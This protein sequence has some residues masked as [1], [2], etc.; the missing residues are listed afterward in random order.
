MSGLHELMS[1]DL[2]EVGLKSYGGGLLA[3]FVAGFDR[4]L[5]DHQPIDVKHRLVLYIEQYQSRSR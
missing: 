2:L 1:A 3:C 5:L 4:E